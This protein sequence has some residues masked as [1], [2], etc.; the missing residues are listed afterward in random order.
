[1]VFEEKDHKEKM[2]NSTLLLLQLHVIPGDLFCVVAVAS[3]AVVLE[4]TAVY[5]DRQLL[6]VS[7]LRVHQ[8]KANFARLDRLRYYDCIL[9]HNKRRGNSR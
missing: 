4:V 5:P 7:H 2:E 3:V 6:R 9:G 1:M 8:R